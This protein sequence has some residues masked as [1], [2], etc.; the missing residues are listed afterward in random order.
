MLSQWIFLAFCFVHFFVDLFD[1]HT[2]THTFD[3]S[4]YSVTYYISLMLGTGQTPNSLLNPLFT[5]RK[6]YDALSL[7]LPT[8]LSRVI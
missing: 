7:K 4:I 5:I 2:Q 1:D 6:S 3:V 8:W